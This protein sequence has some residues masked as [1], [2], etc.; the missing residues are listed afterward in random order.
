MHIIIFPDQRSL[1]AFVET[2][3][4]HKGKIFWRGATDMLDNEVP[5]NGTEAELV[6]YMQT[7]AS[8]K[9]GTVSKVPSTN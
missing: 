2:E 5:P 6:Q 3:G 4:E 1:A 7:L 9:G 8:A